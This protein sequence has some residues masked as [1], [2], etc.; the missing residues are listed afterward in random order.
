[1]TRPRNRFSAEIVF[2]RKNIRIISVCDSYHIPV[3]NADPC[4]SAYIIDVIRTLSIPASGTLN[5]SKGLLVVLGYNTF[6]LTE[7]NNFSA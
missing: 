4:G 2:F 6:F 1:M 5:A 3:T 7:L